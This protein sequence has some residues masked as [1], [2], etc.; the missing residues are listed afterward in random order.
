LS[1]FFVLIIPSAFTGILSIFAVLPPNSFLFG[2]PPFFALR[3]EPT[4]FPQSTQFATLGY[5][6]A[7]T[8]H[9]L[10]SAFII[11]L[12]N[13]YQK[14]HLLSHQ[15][16]GFQWFPGSIHSINRDAKTAEMLKD[17]PANQCQ[18]KWLAQNRFS[19]PGYEP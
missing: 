17:H 9:Q 13:F 18:G 12:D 4:L 11:S 16:M 1:P 14:L 8:A 6:F 2:N 10:L 5:H 15:Q 19:Q 7:E 3:N